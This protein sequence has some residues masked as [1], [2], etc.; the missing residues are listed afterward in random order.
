VRLIPETLEGWHPAE[1]PLTGTEEYGDH[2]DDKETWAV[3]FDE[4]G[5]NIPK[6]KKEE[7]EMK[8]EYK[9]ESVRD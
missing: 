9:V 2:R 8:L 1:D 3:K 6:E 4:I 5:K 7:K